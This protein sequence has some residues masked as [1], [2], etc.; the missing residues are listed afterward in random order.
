LGSAHWKGEH[1]ALR[2]KVAPIFYTRAGEVLQL[3]RQFLDFS[4]TSNRQAAQA[5]A[6]RRVF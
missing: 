5:S 3:P 6:K 1:Q 4:F 2:G